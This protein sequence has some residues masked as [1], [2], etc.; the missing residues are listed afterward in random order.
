M[1]NAQLAEILSDPARFPRVHFAG[2]G[3]IG[4]AGLARLLAAKGFR[5]SGCDAVASPLLSRLAGEGMAVAVGHDPRH[6][7]AA[8][9]AVFSPAVPAEAP[10]RL[11]AT[12]KAFTRGDVLAAQCARRDTLAVAGTHG[13]TT[14]AAMA[15]HVLRAAGIDPDWCIGAEIPSGG[16]P[17]GAGAPD[18]TAFVVEA[19]ESD[20]TLAGYRTRVAVV[21]NIDADHLD[22]FGTIKALEAC[23]ASFLAKS[24]HPAVCSSCPR[25]TALGKTVG[26][27]TFG[28]LATDGVRAEDVS[29]SLAGTEYALCTDGKRL[30]RF[31]L[32]LAGTHQLLDAL[33]AIA[34]AKAWGLDPAQAAEALADFRLPSRRLE[35]LAETDGKF[36]FADYAHHP[37]EIASLMEGVRAM[38]FR[39]IW[40]VFQP[41]RYTR[42]KALAADFPPAFAGAEKVW[43]LPVYAASEPPLAGGTSEDLARTWRETPGAPEVAFA[44]KTHAAEEAAQATNPGDVLLLVGAGD[45]IALAPAIAAVWRA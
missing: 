20:G 31:R 18:G 27:E 21:T 3:G 1:N 30:G 14:T 40:V 32:P 12:G 29:S 19:D 24:A 37:K 39:K 41:H 6:V 35:K 4:M 36:L 5:V 8:D 2:V 42:T 17:G 22:H 13:K 33:G 44:D 7:E 16:F 26:A 38:G 43:L 25:A 34:A 10:E 45:L 11:A 9:W 28:F 23:F 15:L